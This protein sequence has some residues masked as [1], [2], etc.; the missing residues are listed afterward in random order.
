MYGYNPGF[1][2]DAGRAEMQEEEY[3]REDYP[4]GSRV[5]LVSMSK[6]PGMLVDDDVIEP[7]TEGTVTYISR[8]GGNVYISVDWDNGRNLNVIYDV[9]RI[10]RIK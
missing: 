8:G 2:Y 10:T 9:D 5:R 7:G 1:N 3:A 6:Q 4:V